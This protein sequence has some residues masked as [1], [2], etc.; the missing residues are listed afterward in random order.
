MGS[1]GI[2][3]ASLLL[4]AGGI[5]YGIAAG[6][7][8]KNE[9]KRQYREAKDDAARQ[10]A[11]EEAQQILDKNEMLDLELRQ[12]AAQEDTN[13]RLR[14]EQDASLAQVRAQI[15]GMEAKMGEDLLAQQEYAYKR[16]APQLENR[17]NA[18]GLLQSG[19]LPDAQA[20]AQGDLESNR[21]AALANFRMNA[22]NQLNIQQPLAISSADVGR[23]YESL[24]RNLA[25]EQNNLSQQFAN[26]N[27]AYMNEVAR[28]QY[29]AGLASGNTAA[30]QA[31]ANAYMN[32]AGQIGQG[33]LM[34]YGAQKARTPATEDPSLAA[35]YNA[36]Y[37]AGPNY[38]LGPSWRGGR[39]Y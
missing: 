39:I 26:Q 11:K 22:E 1:A 32:F 14:S 35:Y 19:A 38:G 5:G 8:A 33:G 34:Y 36:G 25:T 6:E 17:L 18:L 23:Q 10:R 4:S 31:S 20:K 21:Q 15:P 9:A 16:M 7:N 29:L 30:S 24:G 2:G 27:N 28:Q 37:G 13:R 12:K 3:I